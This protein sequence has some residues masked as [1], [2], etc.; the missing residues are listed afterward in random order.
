MVLVAGLTAC[1]YLLWNWSLGAHQD[2][3]AL[4]AGLT[5]PLA[6]ASML[7]LVLG[8]ARVIGRVGNRSTP[9]R[10]APRMEPRRARRG[11]TLRDTTRQRPDVGDDPTTAAPGHEPEARPSR[12]LAA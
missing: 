4:V 6:A 8:I 12:K 5:L 7:M 10:S 1:D 11:H 2:V 9:D 3:P